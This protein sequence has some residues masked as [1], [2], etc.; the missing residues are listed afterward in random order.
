MGQ[1]SRP[2]GGESLSDGAFR[3]KDR[4]NKLAEHIPGKA[5]EIVSHG[6]IFAALLGYAE[7]TPMPKRTLTHHVPTG[8]VSELIMTNTGWHLFEEGNLP[9]E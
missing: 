5:V 2:E 7:N 1:D 8:S 3:A 9:L 6:E 4:L